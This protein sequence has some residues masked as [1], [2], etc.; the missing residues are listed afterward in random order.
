[1]VTLSGARSD[2]RATMSDG[3]DAVRVIELAETTA[4]LCRG[5]AATRSER[6]SVS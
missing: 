3:G 6:R 5:A 4:T 2:D 1:V